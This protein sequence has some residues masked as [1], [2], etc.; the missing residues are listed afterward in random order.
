MDGKARDYADQR[1]DRHV[2]VARTRVAILGGGAAGLM[3][4]I[5]AGRRLGSGGGST[6]VLVFEAARQ[7]GR[8]ILISGG[9]RCN[10]LPMREEYARFVSASPARLVARFL[11]RFPLDAQVR[12][13]EELLAGPLHEEVETQKRFPPSQRARDVRDV[14]VAKARAEGASLF[15]GTRVR[16]LVQNGEGWRVVF[17]REMDDGDGAPKGV[18]EVVAS[19]VVIA[20]GGRSVLMGGADACGLELAARLG[21]TLVAPYP[22]LAPLIALRAS[23]E[24]PHAFLAGLSVPAT[25]QASCREPAFYAEAHGGFLFTHRGYSGPAVLDVSHVVERARLS[26]QA[27]E[28]RARFGE[29]SL[30]WDVELRPS[31]GRPTGVHGAVK[32]RLPDRLAGMLLD[33]AGI[34]DAPLHRLTRD[35]RRRISGALASF[36]LPVTGTE[37]Y[38]TAE[39]TGGGVALGEVDPGSGRSRLHKGLYFAGEVLD[40]FGPIGGF[41]FQWAWATGRTAGHAA[42]EG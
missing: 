42:S 38:R 25:V 33:S 32:R 17:E 39:V 29:P 15:A 34:P 8:K 2:T 35:E 1:D 12:F 30:D 22:A 16:D 26:G 37:G 41:N 18:S 6:S 19:R 23:G 11:S 24:A 28:V 4:A 36:P 31:K 3:A 20:T 5:A 10:V 7:P 9:G 21:H 14:L 40:A 13:F 27:F